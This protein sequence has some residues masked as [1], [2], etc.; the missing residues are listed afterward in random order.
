LNRLFDDAAYVDVANDEH[1][2]ILSAFASGD[3][4]LPRRHISLDIQSAAQSSRENLEERPRR[5]RQ[6]GD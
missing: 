6:S 1:E 2:S 4:A 3:A 5:K